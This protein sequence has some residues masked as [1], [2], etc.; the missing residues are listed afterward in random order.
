MNELKHKE[1]KIFN[2]EMEIGDAILFNFKV[3]HS[4][5]GNSDNISRK[6][7]SARFIG[8]DV[9]GYNSIGESTTL[10][11]KNLFGLKNG[12]YI[13]FEIKGHSSDKY[14]KGKK[15]KVK[16][17]DLKNGS[18]EIEHRLDIDKK[19]KFRWC[20]AK[21]DI[22]HLDIFRLSKGGPRD[23]AIVAKYCYQD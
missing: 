22:N 6:A 18:F 11:S 15:F 10:K 16:N 19:K 12:H 4:T 17:L 3:L 5:S 13:V 2:T 9:K 8:D 7:F 1:D 21:D 23:K 14:L 20:L